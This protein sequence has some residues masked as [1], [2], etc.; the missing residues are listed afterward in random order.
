MHRL[1]FLSSLEF[2]LICELHS[3]MVVAVVAIRVMEMSVDEMVDVVS[4]RNGLVTAVCT[5]LV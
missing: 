5:V 2:Q 3:A 1:R 4:M